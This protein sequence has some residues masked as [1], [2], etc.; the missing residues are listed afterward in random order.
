MNG[1]VECRLE[2][3]LIGGSCGVALSECSS[4]GV[5]RVIDRGI[6]ALGPGLGFLG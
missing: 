3:E 2:G 6:W 4:I 5:D 1:P